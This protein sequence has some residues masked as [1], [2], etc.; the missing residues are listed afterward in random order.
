MLQAFF[1]GVYN[2]YKT[3]VRTM[4]HFH[5]KTYAIHA[6]KMYPSATD[7][8]VMRHSYEFIAFYFRKRNTG[9]TFMTHEDYSPKKRVVS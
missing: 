2:M 6:Y 3:S 5:L 7:H 8:D 1:F 4:L 9:L